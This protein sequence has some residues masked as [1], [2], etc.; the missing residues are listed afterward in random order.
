[1]T[2]EEIIDSLLYQLEETDALNRD[3]VPI[4]KQAA[5]EI[6][7]MLSG[8]KEIS[9]STQ[10]EK[11]RTL[12]YCP[13]CGKSFRADAREDK[14]CFERYHYHTWYADCPNCKKEVSQNDRYW[15]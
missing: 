10:D 4:P 2:R 5:V 7:R 13:D 1:M 14:E 11:G 9:H 12:F 3:Y 15:R 6:I 8:S